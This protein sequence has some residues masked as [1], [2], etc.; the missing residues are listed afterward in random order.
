[1]LP[2]HRL[3]WVS[4]DGDWQAR[5]DPSDSGLADGWSDPRVPFDRMLRVP[6][7]WQAADPSL[8]QY[9]GVVWYRRA[10]R[11]PAEWRAAEVA[12]HFGAVRHQDRAGLDGHAIGGPGGG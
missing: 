1:M 10:F 12:V 11:V 9:A 7:P 4:L 2:G 3:A 6:L 8:R 5:L